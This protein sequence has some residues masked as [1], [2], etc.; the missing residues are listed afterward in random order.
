MSNVKNAYPKLPIVEF[1]ATSI[2]L[3]DAIEYIASLML[4]VEVKRSCYMIFRNESGNGK[5][6]VNN[7][8]TGVQADGNKLGNGFDEK[9]V[10]TTVKKENMKD[11]N[12]TQRVRRFVCFRSYKE[13]IDY[14]A[15][16]IQARGIYIGGST[17]S[18]YSKIEIKTPKDLANA[19]YKEWVKGDKFATPSV[20]DYKGLIS[21][22]ISAVK[23]IKI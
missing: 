14:L 6:G 9:V 13:S 10:A 11:K 3:E 12:M 1:V 19:Y 16:R 4:N 22:Y 18:V 21:L 15:N 2:K 23:D 7:N 20:I 8:Y 17:N 5:Y